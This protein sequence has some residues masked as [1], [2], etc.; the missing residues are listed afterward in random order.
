MKAS[1]A[2]PKFANNTCHTQLNPIQAKHIEHF[3]KPFFI[4]SNLNVLDSSKAKQ[5]Q[6]LQI[7]LVLP[8]QILMLMY[9]SVSNQN[10]PIFFK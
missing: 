8:N 6:N 4:R 10:K 5:A 3:Q 7:V 2:S 1:K 9:F